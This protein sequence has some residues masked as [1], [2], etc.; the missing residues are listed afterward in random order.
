MFIA[1]AEYTPRWN[2]LLFGNNCCVCSIHNWC[3]W[4]LFRV[5]GLPLL[6]DYSLASTLFI[7]SITPYMSLDDFEFRHVLFSFWLSLSPW[8]S[9]LFLSRTFTVISWGCGNNIVKFRGS[10]SLDYVLRQ[11]FV[12]RWVIFLWIFVPTYYVP[13][14]VVRISRFIRVHRYNDFLP[15]WCR[16]ICKI[17]F[18]K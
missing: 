6:V 15:F 3:V 13:Q 7:N 11:R 17:S 8:S 4:I 14:R 18:K 12:I 2:V 5:Q 1:W 9:S 10:G 16:I